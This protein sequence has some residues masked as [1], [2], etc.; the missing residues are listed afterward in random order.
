ML[1]FWRETLSEY[2]YCVSKTFMIDPAAVKK[3]FIL[4]DRVPNGLPEIMKELAKRSHLA[5]PE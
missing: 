1:L 3:Q 2:S 5:T 4:H